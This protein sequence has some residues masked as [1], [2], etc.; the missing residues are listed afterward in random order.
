MTAPPVIV[1]WVDIIAYNASSTRSPCLHLHMSHSPAGRRFRRAM[2][3]EKFPSW[4]NCKSKET[5][6]NMQGQSMNFIGPFITSQG[7]NS[8]CS[9]NYE[10]LR[11]RLPNCCRSGNTTWQEWKRTKYCRA[12]WHSGLKRPIFTHPHA[13]SYF[14]LFYTLQ[15]W[16]KQALKKVPKLCTCKF[17]LKIVEVETKKRSTNGGR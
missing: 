10:W 8:K 12:R 17:W 11:A 15:N 6:W 16:A 4:Q 7:F 1:L 5:H 9:R 13:H 3:M 14:Q 2:W